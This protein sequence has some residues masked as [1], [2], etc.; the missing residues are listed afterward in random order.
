M[1]MPPPSSPPSTSS[2]LSPEPPQP[3]S[4]PRGASCESPK[5]NSPFPN[6]FPQRRQGLRTRPVGWCGAY[7]WRGY[8]PSI[9][10][11]R[12]PPQ[13]VNHDPP[14]QLRACKIFRGRGDS[15]PRAGVQGGGV[16]P[17]RRTIFSRATHKNRSSSPPAPG[18]L[19]TNGI[20]VAAIIQS[21]PVHIHCF[22][23]RRCRA[24]NRA[25]TDT[26]RKFIVSLGRSHVHW[27]IEHACRPQPSMQRDLHV[28]ARDQLPSCA[29]PSRRS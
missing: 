20:R 19:P 27:R 10:A 21:S 16:A 5:P 9:H 18:L 2:L 26:T 14:P 1:P 3:P 15:V 7:L 23:S 29:A 12:A 6:P 4:G 17:L 25:V 28:H 13:S 24:T 22:A 8:I 11:H